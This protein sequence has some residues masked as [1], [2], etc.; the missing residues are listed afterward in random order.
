M[1]EKQRSTSPRADA[2]AGSKDAIRHVVH[3][4]TKEVTRRHAVL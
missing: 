2:A 3:S 1:L 4:L